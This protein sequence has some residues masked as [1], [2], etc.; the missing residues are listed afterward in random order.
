MNTEQRFKEMLIE[1][2]E[3]YGTV[4]IDIESIIPNIAPDKSLRGFSYNGKYY[5][6]AKI[7]ELSNSLTDK[8]SIEQEID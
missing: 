7:M 2:L 5:S 4:D 3:R 1:Y 6:L 8:E